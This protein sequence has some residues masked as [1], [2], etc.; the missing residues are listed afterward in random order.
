MAQKLW[1]NDSA[2]T[3]IN[4]IGKN[5]LKQINLVTISPESQS[6]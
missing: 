3:E 4:D 1:Q 2:I 6:A 5:F